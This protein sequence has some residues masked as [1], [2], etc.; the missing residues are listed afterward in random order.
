MGETARSHAAR[1][2][3][4]FGFGFTDSAARPIDLARASRTASR[5]FH[6]AAGR[7]SSDIEK[8]TGVYPTAAQKEVTTSM[9]S[10]ITATVHR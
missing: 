5:C 8:N 1:Q 3:A 4:P 6:N 7:A 10:V 9:W 2:V